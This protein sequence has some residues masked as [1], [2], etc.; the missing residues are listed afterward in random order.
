MQLARHTRAVLAVAAMTAL[1]G[2]Q[3]A[4]RPPARAPIATPPPVQQSAVDG[5]WIS[6]D[7]VALS[8][9]SNGR[10]ET[11]ATDT[12]NRLAEGTYRMIDNAS[13]SIS[14]TSLIRQSTVDV[15]CLMISASQLNCTSSTGQNFSLVRRQGVV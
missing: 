7:G 15:N 9:F 5:D 2:C 11:L 4:Q 12:G 10:F 1:A 3:A 13:V 14:M 6:S 8:R